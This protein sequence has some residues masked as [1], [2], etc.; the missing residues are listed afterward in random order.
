MAVPSGGSCHAFRGPMCDSGLPYRAPLAA[1]VQELVRFARTT[2]ALRLA[3][4]N[5]P[6]RDPTFP[7]QRVLQSSRLID[8][9]RPPRERGR[10]GPRVLR[11]RYRLEDL[12][13][14][15]C[16]RQ[17]CAQRSRRSRRCRRGPLG[18]LLPSHAIWRRVASPLHPKL[19]TAFASETG[20]VHAVDLDVG[21]PCAQ[22]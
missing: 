1:A 16:D 12:D 21:S 8:S 22:G 5:R 2:V 19:A 20:P 13:L 18:A 17:K 10:S 15:A 3:S 4:P 6:E 9:G 7:S 14:V 11:I